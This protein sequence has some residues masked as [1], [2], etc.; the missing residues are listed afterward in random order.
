LL[1]Y[2]APPPVGRVGNTGPRLPQGASPQDH[3]PLS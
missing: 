2:T 3:S 1:S